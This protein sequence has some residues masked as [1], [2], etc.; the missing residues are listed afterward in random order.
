MHLLYASKIHALKVLR[1]EGLVN[2]NEPFLNLLT[3]GMVL[4]DVRQNVKIQ[5]QYNVSPQSMIK[6]YGCDAVRFFIIFAAPPEQDLEWSDTGI[7]GA[8]RF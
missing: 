3:Q 7:E 8:F 5:R 4:K 2:T 6:Q 1:D